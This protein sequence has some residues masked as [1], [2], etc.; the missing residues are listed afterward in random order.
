MV[1]SEDETAD[2]SR[3]TLRSDAADRR[4]RGRAGGRFMDAD[5]EDRKSDGF[6]E[7][8]GGS[9]LVGPA[10]GGNKPRRSADCCCVQTESVV[11]NIF[12]LGMTK[13]QVTKR[14]QKIFFFYVKSNNIARWSIC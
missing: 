13:V 11:R 9:R 6:R 1:C 14:C 8:D 3:R 5:E 2:V 12:P 7:D 4:P 10:A